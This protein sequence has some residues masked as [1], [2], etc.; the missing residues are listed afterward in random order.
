MVNSF[1]NRSTFAKVI[2]KHQGVYFFETQCTVYSLCRRINIKV[3]SFKQT[4]FLSEQQ[5]ALWYQKLQQVF[6]VLS[7]SFNTGPQSFCHSFVAPSIILLFEVSP[8][9]RCSVCQ[10]ATVVMATT[11]LVVG[12]FKNFLPHQ[13]RIE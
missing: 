2:I 12:E 3:K 9:N 13:L 4:V 10:V 6:E 5:N 11:Q 8:E 1:E 7:F